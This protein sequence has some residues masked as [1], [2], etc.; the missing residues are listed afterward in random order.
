M[1][2]LT[3][4]E[5]GISDLWPN[6]MQMGASPICDET[7]THAISSGATLS[8]EVLNSRL[9]SFTYTH[10]GEPRHLRL[11]AGGSVF[12]NYSLMV[13]GSIDFGP[14]GPPIVE[15]VHLYHGK[16][17]RRQVVPCIIYSRPKV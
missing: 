12:G 16:T 10:S 8:F 11:F 13:T 17:A 3:D 6:I 4:D 14:T 2:E 5:L 9:K 7:Q 15:S 1:D